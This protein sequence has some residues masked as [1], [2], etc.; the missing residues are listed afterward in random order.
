MQQ[1]R[2]SPPRGGLQGTAR[3]LGSPQSDAALRHAFR[4]GI[5]DLARARTRPSVARGPARCHRGAAASSLRSFV[6]PISMGGWT[7]SQSG[8]SG[9]FRGAGAMDP[10]QTTF[11]RPFRRLRGPHDALDRPGGALRS[12]RRVRRTPECVLQAAKGIMSS[13]AD[14]LVT[15]DRAGVVVADARVCPVR[16]PQVAAPALAATEAVRRAAAGALVCHGVRPP[17]G[18]GRACLHGVYPPSGG[19]RACLHGVRPPSGGGRL[20]FTESV[21]R[22]AAGALVF[23]ESV[24]RAA[25]GALVCTESHPPSGGGRACLHGGRPP[26]GGGRACLHGV[27]P[28]SGGGRACLHGGRREPRSPA[29]ERA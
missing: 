22:A 5:A 6:T 16:V 27:H 17:S 24:R 9:S 3:R 12:A 4:R 23:T 8:R 15:T 14:P 18:G 1:Q 25:A 13:A 19:G 10:H 7:G 28:P 21:R 29:F 26:S 20:V 2:C 11:P